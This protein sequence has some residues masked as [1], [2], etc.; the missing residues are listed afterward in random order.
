MSSHPSSG[1]GGDCVEGEGEPAVDGCR[2]GWGLVDIGAYM[3]RK[4]RCCVFYRVRK[5]LRG[6]MPVGR[7][8]RCTRVVRVRSVEAVRCGAHLGPL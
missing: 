7:A 8:L 5:V 3:Q 1:N 2:A 4:V 6:E